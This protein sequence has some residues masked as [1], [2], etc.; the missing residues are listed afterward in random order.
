LGR[1]VSQHPTSCILLCAR[2]ILQALHAQYRHLYSLYAQFTH[3]R[4]E[5]YLAFLAV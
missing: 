2:S 4:T 1:N 3:Q 5:R